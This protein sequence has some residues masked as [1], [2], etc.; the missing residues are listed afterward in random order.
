M[1]QVLQNARDADEAD[2]AER[3]R[4]KGVRGRGEGVGCRVKVYVLGVGC[5]V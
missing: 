1:A 4:V 2:K 5:S 3:C